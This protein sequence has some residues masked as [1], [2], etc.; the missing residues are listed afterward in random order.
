MTYIKDT[1][2]VYINLTIYIYIDFIRL[3]SIMIF[4]SKAMLTND[5]SFSC[6]IKVAKLVNNHTGSM[7]INY[8][9]SCHYF[10]TA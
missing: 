7:Y 9:T 8:A 2:A 10:E 6:N 4:N 1:A 3:V 5:T